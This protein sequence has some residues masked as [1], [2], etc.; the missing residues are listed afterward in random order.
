[1]TGKHS[2]NLALIL[3]LMLTCKIKTM[4]CTRWIPPFRG[5]LRKEG[6]EII[7]NKLSL[8]RG[9]I[10]HQ[11]SIIGLEDMGYTANKLLV[12][13]IHIIGVGNQVIKQGDFMIHNVSPCQ[14]H[15]QT[16][17]IIHPKGGKILATTHPQFIQTLVT[18]HH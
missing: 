17:A 16:L 11:Y 4:L 10:Q 2:V 6:E 18:K 13:V 5:K 8:I 7:R 1:M 3:K 12:G 9:F 14:G 15:I